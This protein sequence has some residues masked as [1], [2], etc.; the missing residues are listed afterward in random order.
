MIQTK[1]DWAALYMLASERG[2]ISGY[3]ELCRLVAEE[4]SGAPQPVRQSLAGGEWLRHGRRFPDWQPEGVRYDKFRRHYLI[5][6]AAAPL[7][8]VS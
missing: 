2:Y 7:L 5:A 3:T 6:Q 1:T 8:P 4:A